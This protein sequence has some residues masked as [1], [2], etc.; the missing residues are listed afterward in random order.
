MHCMTWI[1][2]YK[3]LQQDRPYN[4][5]KRWISMGVSSLHSSAFQTNN[6]LLPDRRVTHTHTHKT[7]FCHVACIR[8]HTHINL[9]TLSPSH[10]HH[11]WPS[12]YWPPC[13]RTPVPWVSM[14]D[15]GNTWGLA[16]KT[17][18]SSEG[19]STQQHTITSQTQGARLIH[20]PLHTNSA[21]AA[22]QHPARD[23]TFIGRHVESKIWLCW[24]LWPPVLLWTHTA[25]VMDV[26]G[27]N[28]QAWGLKKNSLFIKA[29]SYYCALGS[30]KEAGKPKH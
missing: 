2:W 23:C 30:S 1:G 5:M 12:S 6:G 9:H 4:N 22:P 8:T 29:A 16:I 11:A 13:A 14:C 26:W 19:L 24:T 28:I 10:T 15:A 27:A 17:Q 3:A 21:G 25:S 20:E 7:W 18:P